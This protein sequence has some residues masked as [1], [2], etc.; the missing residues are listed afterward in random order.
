MEHQALIK[1]E[2]LSGPV[3]YIR[4]HP[5]YYAYTQMHTTKETCVISGFRRD[6]DEICALQGHYTAQN[7]LF[8]TDVSGCI[9]DPT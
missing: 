3:C 4:F 2:K 1:I 6:V 8:R 9:I 7:F 5:D